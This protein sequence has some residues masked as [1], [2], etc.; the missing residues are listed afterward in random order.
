M[1]VGEYGRFA[2]TAFVVFMT[3]LFGGFVIEFL[4]YALLNGI[5]VPVGVANWVFAAAIIGF[6][7]WGTLVGIHELRELNSRWGDG[8]ALPL[9]VLCVSGAVVAFS[10]YGLAD[11]WWKNEET[12]CVN[13]ICRTY[14]DGELEDAA[15]A[16]SGY[17]FN[18]VVFGASAW[19][20]GTRQRDSRVSA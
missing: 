14:S 2:W 19:W 11:G 12:E 16:L 13:G 9:I 6:A 8:A 4:T 20:L 1:T 15:G 10:T 3:I 17:T 5:D 7:S 18:V